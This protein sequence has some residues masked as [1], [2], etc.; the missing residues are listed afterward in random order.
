M[1]NSIDF[2]PIETFVARERERELA[3]KEEDQLLVRSVAEVCHPAAH[4]ASE[5]CFMRGC[6]LMTVLACRT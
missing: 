2:L 4:A 6:R 1:Q 5:G 3:R